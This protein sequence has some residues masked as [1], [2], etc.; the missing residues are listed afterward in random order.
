MS[1]P[2]WV[3]AITLA[4]VVVLLA[5]DLFIIGRRPHEPSTKEATL[6]VSFYIALSVLFGLGVWLIA[7]HDFGG[8]FFAGYITEY[9][10]SMD[11]LF[12]FMVIMTSFSVPRQFQQKALMVGIIVALVLRGVFILIGAELVNRFVWIFFLFGAFLIFTGIQQLRHGNEEEEV[13]ENVIIRMSRRMMPVA[14]G[15]DSGRMFTKVNGRRMVTPMLIVMIALG[16]TDLLFAVDSIPATF[17]LTQEGF[18][19]FTVNVFALMGLRQLYFLLGGLLERLVYLSY[20]LAAILGFIG[21][22]LILHALA[23]NDLPF[24]NNGDPGGGHRREP[25]VPAEVGAGR[26]RRPGRTRRRRRRRR[27]HRSGREP[28]DGGIAVVGQIEGRGVDGQPG[29]GSSPPLVTETVWGAAARTVAPHTAVQGPRVTRRSPVGPRGPGRGLSSRT[30]RSGRRPRRRRR[31]P[32]TSGSARPPLRPSRG[33][34]RR[35]R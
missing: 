29:H 35:S 8:Q 24:I 22:K 34:R 27:R 25:A 21:V 2:A 20:G 7:G 31:C 16:T 19:V 12:V 11:N 33:I 6:W 13:K 18:L 28:A 1:T 26:G 10:M 23:E 5:I 14:D 3:W 15:F 4:A 30:P 32:T 17:G 9:S